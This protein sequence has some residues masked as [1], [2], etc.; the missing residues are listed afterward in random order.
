M[1]A[2]GRGEDLLDR[3]DGDGARRGI[4]MDGAGRSFDA[5][6]IA[7]DD[8]AVVGIVL[9]DGRREFEVE[10]GLLIEEAVR[11]LADAADLAA[12]GRDR[13]H[14]SCRGRP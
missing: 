10:D 1:Q 3:V 2:R 12:L 8:D 11:D 4:A 7:L 5:C 13:R 14:W 9:A 6:W